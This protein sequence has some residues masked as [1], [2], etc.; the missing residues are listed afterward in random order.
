M[1]SYEITFMA[2]RSRH[3]HG[4][5]MLEAV[6]AEGLQVFFICRAIEFF[7]FGAGAPV[8]SGKDEN[9]EHQ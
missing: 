2:P 7:Q 1:N 5:S 4:E 6:K 9:H 8:A 3:H